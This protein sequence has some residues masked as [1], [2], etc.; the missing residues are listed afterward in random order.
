MKIE[1]SE[2][3]REYVKRIFPSIGDVK[4]S[5]KG[6]NSKGVYYEYYTSGAIVKTDEKT[7]LDIQL[8]IE[9]LLLGTYPF[10]P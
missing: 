3:F 9:S 1:E 10:K 6:R 7:V 8:P 5:L 4:Y 2:R